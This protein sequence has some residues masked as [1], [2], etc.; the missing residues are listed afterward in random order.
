[1][2]ERIDPNS[3]PCLV[4]LFSVDM[5]HDFGYGVSILGIQNH[6]RLKGTRFKGN[7]ES[8]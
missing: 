2:Y 1:M 6:F 8:F 3:L 4:V 5:W 7:F